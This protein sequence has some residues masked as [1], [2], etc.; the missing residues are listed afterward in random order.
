VNYPEEWRPIRGLEGSYSVSDRG[1]VRSE[2]REVPHYRGGVS[3]RRGLTISPEVDA[4]GYRRVVLMSGGRRVH[5]SIHRLVCEAFH[6]PAPE[7]KPFSLH[8]DGNPSNNK[9]SNVR[10]GSSWDNMADKVLH[11]TNHELNK[12]HCPHRHP[13][14][15]ENLYVVPKTGK[16][17][18]RS[19][20]KRRREMR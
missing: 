12:T 8:G 20:A 17:Q 7:G 13:Y 2:D 10:W 6:G 9:V 16:R 1:R 5:Q 14:S 3:L 11:G 4:R 18:C 19:C 15:G